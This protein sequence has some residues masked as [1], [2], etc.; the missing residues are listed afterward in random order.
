MNTLLWY[1]HQAARRL[2]V[3]GLAG[4]ALLVAALG[5]WLTQFQPLKQQT[6]QQQQ[7]LASLRLAAQKP[8]VVQQPVVAADPLAA[9][10]PDSSA[11]PALGELEQLARAHGFELARGSYSVASVA[12]TSLARW[13]FVLPLK[14]EFSALHAFAAAAL[15]RLPNL[16]LDEIKL[17]RERIE[18][19]T[20]DAEL[21]FS[22]FVETAP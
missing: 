16:A 14:A 22:L 18:D 20:L 11:A 1:A 4:L 7:A 5:V 13:Q 6:Q 9:L 15:E 3:V 10:P 17:K 2:G 21:R 19:T 8:V 12:H